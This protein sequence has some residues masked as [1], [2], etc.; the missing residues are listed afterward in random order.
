MNLVTDGLILADVGAGTDDE[1]IGE[2]GNLAKIED[3]DVECFFG[4]GRTNGF[5]QFGSCSG[6]SARF[7]DAFTTVRSWSCLRMV[8]SC[9]HRTTISIVRPSGILCGI[10]VSAAFA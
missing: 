9:P 3:D 7:S 5:S 4:L 6:F 8:P 1:V 10:F 2:A